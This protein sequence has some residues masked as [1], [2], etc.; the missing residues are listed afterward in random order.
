MREK[1]FTARYALV[2]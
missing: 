2:L 1:M